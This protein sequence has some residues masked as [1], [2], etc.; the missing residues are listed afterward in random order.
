MARR[1]FQAVVGVTRNVGYGDKRDY[2][3]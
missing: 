1:V 3:V 2:L